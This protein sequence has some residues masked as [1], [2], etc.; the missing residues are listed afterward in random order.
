[1]R[2]SQD[3]CRRS[4]LRRS[5]DGLLLLPRSDSQI[6]TNRKYRTQ[7]EKN[8]ANEHRRRSLTKIQPVR[9]H[10]CVRVSRKRQRA[11]VVCET[12]ELL[13]GRH[14]SVKVSTED[15]LISTRGRQ[16]RREP[17]LGIAREPIGL[18]GV[19]V[20]PANYTSFCRGARACLVRQSW[21]ISIFID[22]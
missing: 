8:T 17:N 13:Y 4:R 7:E 9:I 18:R 19:G 14:R 2:S 20:R 15:L 21:A 16:L 11:A 1:M 6:D 5:E 3:S 10:A 12:T 22:S